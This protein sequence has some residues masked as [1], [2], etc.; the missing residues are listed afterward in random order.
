MQWGDDR[1]EPEA[2]TCDIQC[3]FLSKS[4]TFFW[5]AWILQS[6]FLIIKINNFWGDLSDISGKTATLVASSDVHLAG[7]SVWYSQTRFIL[8]VKKTF[9]GSKHP[10]TFN[11]I[12][13]KASL[14]KASLDNIERGVTFFFS[15][16]AD[17]SVTSPRKSFNFIAIK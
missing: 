9:K 17:T 6:Y 3:S 15:V 7:T 4:H 2:N 5:D 11:F 1:V 8:I 13:K 14:V 10:K 12:S 16:L